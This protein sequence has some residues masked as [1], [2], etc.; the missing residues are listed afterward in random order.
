MLGGRAIRQI[1]YDPLLPPPF[2]DVGERR[3]FIET[4]KIMDREGRRIWQR[5]FA[6]SKLE[7]AAENVAERGWSTRSLSNGAERRV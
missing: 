2:V 4:M 7:A 3:A 6:F 5:F 1:V